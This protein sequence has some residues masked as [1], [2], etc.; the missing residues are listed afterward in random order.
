MG[1][2]PIPGAMLKASVGQAS[3]DMESTPGSSSLDGTTLGHVRH[4]LPEGPSER[5]L[6]AHSSI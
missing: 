1:V 6:V 4:G 2:P 3:W 5:A